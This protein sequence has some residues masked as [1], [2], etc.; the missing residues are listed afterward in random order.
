MDG[1]GRRRRAET[2]G[3]GCLRWQ[4]GCGH[5]SLL[6]EYPRS[7]FRDQSARNWREKRTLFSG[8]PHLVLTTP[9]EWLKAQVE[10]SFLGQYPVYALP[11]GIDTDAFAPCADEAFLRNAAHYYGLDEAEGRHLVL[12]VAS[13]WEPRKGLE[14]LL[15]LAEKLGPEYC[16]AAVGLDEYQIRSLPEKSVLG[17]PRTGNLNDLCALYTAADLCVSL[18]HAETM[19]MTL[20]EALACGTQ[21][22]CWDVTAMPEIV[23]DEVGRTVP[24][25]DYNGLA[26]TVRELCDQPKSPRDCRNR[27]LE[28]AAPRRYRAY[29]R[30]YDGMYRN[31]PGYLQA[32]E[33]AC[34]VRTEE[35]D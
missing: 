14:D 23:T 1:G 17:I 2:C 6:R 34:R 26:Q 25:G 19:G 12:S 7:W 13:T 33:E 10:S 18:S 4:S 35:D 24:M 20:V 29:M 16:V 30:L 8:L 5:C 31:G 11:N 22:L 9:S 21:V 27:A 15:E 28:Y 3:E 32:V